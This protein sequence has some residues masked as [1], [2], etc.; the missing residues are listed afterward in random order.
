MATDSDEDFDLYEDGEDYILLNESD[1][2]DSSDTDD[3]IDFGDDGDAPDDESDTES[4]PAASPP[5][6]QPPTAPGEPRVEVI[7]VVPADERIMSAR[8]SLFEY[9]AMLATRARAIAEG[10][11]P[12]VKIEAGDSARDLAE[13]ELAQ[14]QSPLRVQRQYMAY[15]HATGTSEK[16]VEYWPASELQLP[17]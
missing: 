11:P 2:E 5:P 15:D 14:R 6:P 10:S 17:L 8:A 12:L 7:R 16:R 1:E 13:R 9:A 4:A 3:E